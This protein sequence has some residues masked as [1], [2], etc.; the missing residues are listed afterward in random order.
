MRDDPRLNQ[1]ALARQAVLAEGVELTDALV[2]AWLD[3][4]GASGWLRRLIPRRFF[5]ALRSPCRLQGP[6]PASQPQ[7]RR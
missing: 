1:I 2:S 6:W 5:H 4:N 3:R 7:C